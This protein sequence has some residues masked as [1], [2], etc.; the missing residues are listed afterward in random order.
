[1]SEGV[2]ESNFSGAWVASWTNRSFR[3][4][5]EISNTQGRQQYSHRNNNH[6]LRISLN[7]TELML[8]YL[9]NGLTAFKRAFP[10]QITYLM[11]TRT[12]LYNEDEDIKTDRWLRLRRSQYLLLEPLLSKYPCETITW[13]TVHYY[14]VP[15]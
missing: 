6:G 10:F 9:S 14:F 4:L 3:F 11:R 15:L 12:S 1:M 5:Y 8:R 7:L 2:K 13:P